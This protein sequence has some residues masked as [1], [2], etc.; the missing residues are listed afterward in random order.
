ML[1][2]KHISAYPDAYL[3]LFGNPKDGQEDT[4][5][6]FINAVE[7]MVGPKGLKLRGQK[8]K[9]KFKGDVLEVLAEL[10]FTRLNSDPAFGLTEYKPT[11]PND[12]FG[13]DATGINANG[14]LSVVQVKYRRNPQNEIRWKDLA[15]TAL[16]GI[17]NFGIDG[18]VDRNVFLFTTAFKV[19][20]ICTKRFGNHLVIINRAIIQR[21]ID[22]NR[23]F[24]KLC[25][26]DVQEYV[27][28]HSG[29]SYVI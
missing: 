5:R 16:D 28:Y 22:N 27:Q 25:F 9:Y 11:N 26:A 18:K 21:T 19:N 4:L 12:D 7:R 29:C 20:W 13:V 15:K 2:V 24:W 14:H 3:S 8:D 10:F 1:K 17:Y 6:E 23:N